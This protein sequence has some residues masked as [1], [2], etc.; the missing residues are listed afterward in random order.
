MPSEYKPFGPHGRPVD[1]NRCKASVYSNDRAALFHQCSR[2]PWKDGWC[3]QHH[4]DSEKARQ[5]ASA[6]R[7]E[8]HLD[9]LPGMRAA[10]TIKHLRA[11]NADL[12]AILDL[13]CK[14]ADN[15]E[16]HYSRDCDVEGRHDTCLL[17]AAIREGHIAIAKAKAKAD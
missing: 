5:E 1:P 3:K 8:R 4:P 17:C 11:I 12:L 14:A 9:N 13:L 10:R 15:G 16:W 6:E 2:K 7:Y